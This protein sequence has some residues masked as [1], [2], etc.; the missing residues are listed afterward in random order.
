MS[1][2]QLSFAMFLV[3]SMVREKLLDFGAK[4]T[5]VM[6]LSEHF[7]SKDLTLNFIGDVRSVGSL[8]ENARLEN[9]FLTGHF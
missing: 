7:L 3:L 5:L 9:L 4:A 6:L 2:V 8:R 1:I